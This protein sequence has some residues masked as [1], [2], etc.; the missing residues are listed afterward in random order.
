MT[1]ALRQRADGSIAFAAAAASSDRVVAQVLDS[2]TA[3]AASCPSA[4]D[5]HGCFAAAGAIG[6]AKIT[7]DVSSLQAGP[8]PPARARNA[9]SSYFQSLSYLQGAMHQLVIGDYSTQ[10]AV[11]T[12]ALPDV[13]QQYQSLYLVL[14][15]M[16]GVQ[17]T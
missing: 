6:E 5:P 4:P 2:I 7:A 17:S 12:L 16:V 9:L 10:T 8:P 1:T 14:T 3:A 13:T 15:S 11:L